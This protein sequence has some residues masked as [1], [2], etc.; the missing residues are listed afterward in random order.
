MEL[1]WG[2]HNIKPYHKGC[3]LAIGNFDGFHRGHQSLIAILNKKKDSFCLPIMVMIFEPQPQEYF[4][5]VITIRLTRLRDKIHYLFTA[6]VDVVLCMKFNQQLASVEAYSFVKKILIYKLGVRCICVG[7]DF[8]F[9][10]FKKGDLNFLKK[11]GQYEGFQVICADTCLDKYGCKISS[12]EIRTALL[13]DRIVDAELLM[14]HSYCVSGRVIH[15][16]SL[17]RT[18]G[19]PTANISLQ[20][21]QL[22]V[23]GVYIVQVYGIF[24]LPLPGIANIGIRPTIFGTTQQQLEVHILNISMNLYYSHISVVILDKIRD[25]QCFC[26][27]TMLRRQ[28]QRDIMQVRN[29]FKKCFKRHK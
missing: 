9:G 20:G 8:K 12:T 13:E 19:F 6:G 29:Y 28:I 14:G 1:V 18:I 15:G 10:S 3:I 21:K 11:A 2:L 4:S 7:A 16:N 27:I 24:N 25:E 17:G 23:Q 22:P 5:K 26:S